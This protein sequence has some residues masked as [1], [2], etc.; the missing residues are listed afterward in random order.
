MDA[1]E[2]RL[3]RLE[4][5]HSRCNPEDQDSLLRC[6]DAAKVGGKV[7]SL[8]VAYN[9]LEEDVHNLR[10]A[11]EAKQKRI[12]LL[13]HELQTYQAY[14]GQAE[15]ANRK[16]CELEKRLTTLESQSYFSEETLKHCTSI[17]SLSNRVQ[18][19]ERGLPSLLPNVST[20][21]LA[22]T[23]LP[24]LTGGDV[25]DV[26]V[27][28][29]LHSALPPAPEKSFASRAQFPQTPSLTQGASCA[30]TKDGSTDED[31][32]FQRGRRSPLKPGR[33]MHRS[34]ARGRSHS[35]LS[36]KSK[37]PSLTDGPTRASTSDGSATDEPPLKRRRGRSRKHDRLPSAV[38]S[39]FEIPSIF[40]IE[41]S[42]EPTEL[43][44]GNKI[45]VASREVS[46][47]RKAKRPRVSQEDYEEAVQEPM[48]DWDVLDGED[49][50]FVIPP[51]RRSGRKATPAKQYGD[52]IPWKDANASVKA[53]RPS[54]PRR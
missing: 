46:G 1:V 24:R 9:E 27:A 39:S 47:G 38:P 18:Q 30:A 23:L 44:E 25:L 37:T 10:E 4:A 43:S 41:T 34:S 17:E 22:Q 40:E 45:Q 7:E 48:H 14:E 52:M 42:A 28:L 53:M 21:S 29:Q 15:V 8:G 11:D 32:P 31:P 16:L 19:L 49:Q 35:L 33:N 3:R 12:D 54:G 6:D 13:E 5:V 2:Q 50:R 36:E 51:E 20:H 26:A